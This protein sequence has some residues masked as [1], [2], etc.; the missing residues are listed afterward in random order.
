MA[1]SASSFIPAVPVQLSAR[2]L[3]RILIGHRLAFGSRVL[4]VGWGTG[5]LA[6]FLEDI[7]FEVSGI[8]DSLGSVDEAREMFPRIEFHAAQPSESVPLE[9][10]SYDLVLVQECGSYTDNL[11]GLSARIATA[12]LLACLKPGGHAVFVRPFGDDSPLP[13]KHHQQNCWT[14]HLACFPGEAAISNYADPW[15]SRSTWGWL[16]GRHARRGYYTVSWRAPQLLV[17]PDRWREFAK[18]GLMTG[19]G[20]CCEAANG[21]CEAGKRRVA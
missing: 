15:L 7:S 12:N 11:L 10:H 5:E 19:Q 6:S 21:C 17:S 3:S 16:R 18:R 9:H 2:V 13:M 20:A 8:D 4:L 14:R 1:Y